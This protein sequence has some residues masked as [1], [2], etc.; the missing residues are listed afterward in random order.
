MGVKVVNVSTQHTHSARQWSPIARLPVISPYPSAIRVWD[1]FKTKCFSPSTLRWHRRSKKRFTL[2]GCTTYVC[3]IA[4]IWLI[5]PATHFHPHVPRPLAYSHVDAADNSIIGQL[6]NG[7]LNRS[8]DV[9]II[10]C[11][12]IKCEMDEFS[13]ATRVFIGYY[14]NYWICR[15]HNRLKQTTWK[16]VRRN[17]G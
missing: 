2:T 4:G 8:A 6:T 17:C 5:Q 10:I 11:T 3:K 13:M 12:P 1:T 14:W 16:C 15:N 7:T 9:F